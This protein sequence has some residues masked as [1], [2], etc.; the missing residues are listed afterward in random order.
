MRFGFTPAVNAI[1][2]IIGAVTLVVVVLAQRLVVSK[3][4]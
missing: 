3:A 2:T 4:N 1:F